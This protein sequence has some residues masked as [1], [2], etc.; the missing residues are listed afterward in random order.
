MELLVKMRHGWFSTQ[1]EQTSP[2][3]AE[4]LA[5]L[6]GYEITRETPYLVELTNPDDD[7]PF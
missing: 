4:A 3:K 6:Q 1:S 7:C 2:T 5:T